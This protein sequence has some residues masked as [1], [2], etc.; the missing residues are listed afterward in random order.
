MAKTFIFSYEELQPDQ[1]FVVAGTNRGIGDVMTLIQSQWT[2][3]KNFYY[4]RDYSAEHATNDI[5]V[6]EVG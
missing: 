4:H 3:G 1:I 2:V 6:I 5:G